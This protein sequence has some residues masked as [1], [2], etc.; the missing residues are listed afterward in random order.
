MKLLFP[1]KE[2]FV[3]MTDKSVNLMVTKQR[4]NAM[5]RK[6]LANKIPLMNSTNAKQA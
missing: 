5:L 2:M 4:R 1:R 6:K 3:G